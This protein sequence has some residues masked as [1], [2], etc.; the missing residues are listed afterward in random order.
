MFEAVEE[1][2]VVVRASKRIRVVKPAQH[3]GRS[4]SILR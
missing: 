1:S 3:V 2:N 4:G